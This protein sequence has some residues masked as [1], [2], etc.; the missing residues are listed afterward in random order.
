M[1]RREKKIQSSGYVYGGQ[2]LIIPCLASNKKRGRGKTSV[3]VLVFGYG[4]S[5]G[6]DG[7][8]VV[9]LI[10]WD[11]DMRY[12]PASFRSWQPGLRCHQAHQASHYQA[13]PCPGRHCT[14][15]CK[16]A[17]FTLHV[18]TQ[19]LTTGQLPCHGTHTYGNMVSIH[20][21]PETPG[22]LR[23]LVA[24]GGNWRGRTP[25]AAN[26]GLY[27]RSK[28]RTDAIEKKKSRETRINSVSVFLKR[29]R[30]AKVAG[31]IPCRG[32][33]HSTLS[34]SRTSFKRLV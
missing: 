6:G 23:A 29:H 32:P 33:I 21:R 14:A 2:A 7:L 18:P 16:S 9:A 15:Q 8:L 12:S 27:V 34:T 20:R 19:Q 28:Q 4:P 22:L 25:R 17:S 11:E 31:L 30:P 3:G 13:C 1:G 26:Q 24:W 10:R 5:S